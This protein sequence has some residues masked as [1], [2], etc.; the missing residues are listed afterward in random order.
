[1]HAALLFFNSAPTANG[2]S[3]TVHSDGPIGSLLANDSDPDP[4]DTLSSSIVTSPTNRSLTNIGTGIYWYTRNS[5]TWTGT[6]SFTYKACDNQLPRLCSAPVTVNITVVNQPPVAVDDAYNI[7]GA[8]A[9]GPFKANDSDPD[10][11]PL[12]RVMLTFP[13]DC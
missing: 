2:D 9:I 11:D 5:S 6:D 12:N 10:G 8:T 7:H 1:M 3:Y 4:G 13:T